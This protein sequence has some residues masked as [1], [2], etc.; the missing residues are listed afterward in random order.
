M[1]PHGYTPIG[2]LNVGDMVTGSNGRAT[3]I[4]GVYPQG[5]QEICEVTFSD[6]SVQYRDRFTFNEM[7][8]EVD[9]TRIMHLAQA[10]LQVAEDNPCRSFTRGRAISAVH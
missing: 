2:K 7:Y 3:R 6:G 10:G 9:H 1:T 8:N 5:E 4:I